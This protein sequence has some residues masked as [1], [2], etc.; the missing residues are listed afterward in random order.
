MVRIS[1]RSLIPFTLVLT[2]AAGAR[3][4]TIHYGPESPL[5]NGTARSYILLDGD[6]PLELGFALSESALEGLPELADVPDEEAF[7][8]LDLEPPAENPTP[9]RLTAMDWNPRGHTPADVYDVPHFDFHFYLV[10]A[11][12]RDAILPEDPADY[13]AFEARGSR[14]PESGMLPVAYAYAPESTVPQMGAHWVDPASHEF[15]G[16]A[17]D[18]TFIYGT[19]EGEVVFWEPM[20]TK[21][22]IE[23]RPDAVIEVAVPEHVATPGWYPTAYRVGFD[24][25]SKEYRIALV[26]FVER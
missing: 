5:G 23:S 11:G 14:A 16:T 7:V 4:Q 15:H 6:R 25:A 24:E 9:F 17:F 22:Y 18:K 19:W 13:A 26:G 12:R 3:G 21:A 8:L 1:F 20:I 2:L 10:D